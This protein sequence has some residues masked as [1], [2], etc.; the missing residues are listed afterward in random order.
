MNPGSNVGDVPESTQGS[1]SSSIEDIYQ[2]LDSGR[3]Q[4]RLLLLSPGEV[5]DPICGALDVVSLDDHAKYEA[6]SYVWGQDKAA[7]PM[8]IG[9]TNISLTRNLDTALRHLRYRD[10]ARA[11]WVDAICIYFD[12]S[13]T[14]YR[15]NLRFGPLFSEGFRFASRIRFYLPARLLTYSSSR[16]MHPCF[17]VHELPQV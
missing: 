8:V 17:K 9:R 4:I 15:R 3:F 5:K 2:S 6:L 7:T 10:S 12:R 16:C 14:E 11:L 13:P 1:A